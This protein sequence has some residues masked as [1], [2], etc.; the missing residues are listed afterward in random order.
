MGALESEMQNRFRKRQY[1]IFYSDRGTLSTTGKSF[2]RTFSFYLLWVVSGFTGVFFVRQAFTM[3][4]RNAT[5]LMQNTG[6]QTAMRLLSVLGLFVMGVSAG[7]L[8]K[9]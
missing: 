7:K 6:V 4:S 1:I 5:G 9:V 2:R 3:E 8:C